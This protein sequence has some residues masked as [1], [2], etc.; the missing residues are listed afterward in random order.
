MLDTLG[1]GSVP[2][3]GVHAWLRRYAD[4]GMAALADKSSEPE[5]CPHQMAPMIEA[6][7]VELRR[8]PVVWGTQTGY[9]LVC[10]SPTTLVSRPCGEGQR[11]TPLTVV[12][13]VLGALVGGKADAWRSEVQGK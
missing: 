7:V 13:I 5:S 4:G 10:G 6:R 11:K 9:A 1:S 12:P 3:P 8:A 2:L